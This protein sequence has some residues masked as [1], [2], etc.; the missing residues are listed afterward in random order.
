M[1]FSGEKFNKVKL[2]TIKM[3]VF[4]RDVWPDLSIPI[5]SYFTIKTILINEYF[6][7]KKYRLRVCLNFY[8]KYKWPLAVT[9]SV[10]DCFINELKWSS[11]T[12][13]QTYEINFI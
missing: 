13:R 3:S 4:N 10:V 1:G 2:N 9:L 11:T 12:L 5:S 8:N 7:L 6:V